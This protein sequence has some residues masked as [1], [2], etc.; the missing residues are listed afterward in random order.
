MWDANLVLRLRA[1]MA[2]FIQDLR[3]S[4]RTYIKN[5]AFTVVAVLSLT[6]GIALNTVVFSIVEALFL[7]PLPGSD[8][9]RLVA[10][11]STTPQG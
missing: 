7:R 5:R 4:L 2:G 11:V 10:L 8:P 3:Y 1:V 9:S 6:F